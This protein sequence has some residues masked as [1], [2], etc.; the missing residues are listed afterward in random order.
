MKP[1]LESF[2]YVVDFAAAGAVLFLALRILLSSQENKIAYGGF[3]GVTLFGVFAY[4]IVEAL[5]D[6]W[7]RIR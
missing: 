7:E 2:P 6:I 5:A 4:F 1:K 3:L